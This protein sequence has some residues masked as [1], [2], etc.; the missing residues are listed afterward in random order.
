MLVEL[1]SLPSDSTCVLE[2]E[3]GKLDIERRE[4]GFTHWFT[5]QNGDLYDVI[6]DF[7]VYSTLSTSFKKC[8]VMLT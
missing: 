5:L 4:P 7:R 8:K 1:R 6:I 3:P 2:A